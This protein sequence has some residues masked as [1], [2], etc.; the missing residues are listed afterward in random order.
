[1]IHANNDTLDTI[2]PEEQALG[3]L[4]R[5]EDACDSSIHYSKS[6]GEIGLAE[7]L[8]EIINEQPSRRG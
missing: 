2:T 1:M 8:K 6:N 3:K 7:F 5:V 4:K